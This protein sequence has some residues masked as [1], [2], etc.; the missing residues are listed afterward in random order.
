MNSDSPCAFAVDSSRAEELIRAFGGKKCFADDDDEADADEVDEARLVVCRLGEPGV[1][2]VLLAQLCRSTNM[3]NDFL[4]E[5]CNKE[6][7][8]LEGMEED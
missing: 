1:I 4:C 2:G 3:S 5:M 8:L 7:A 6:N